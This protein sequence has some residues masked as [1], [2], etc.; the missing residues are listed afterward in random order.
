[1]LDTVK[2]KNILPIWSREGGGRQ[3]NIPMLLKQHDGVCD[4][5]WERENDELVEEE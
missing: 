5:L 1:M 3:F 4:G 2:V